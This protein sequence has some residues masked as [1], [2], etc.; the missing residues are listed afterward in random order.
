MVTRRETGFDPAPRREGLTT[1]QPNHASADYGR[2]TRSTR[3]ADTAGPAPLSVGIQRRDGVAIVQPH[4]ELDLGTVET[5]RAA[6]DGTRNAPKLV[7]D[8]RRLSFIDST[9][10]HLLVALEQSAQRDGMELTLIAPPAP[11]RRVIE[12]CGLDKT[13]RFV[14]ALDGEPCEPEAR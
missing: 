5:L 7:L 10:V 1:M 4:G 11:V 8:L 13:L 14:A 3:V 9:G 6:L 2:D 12:L